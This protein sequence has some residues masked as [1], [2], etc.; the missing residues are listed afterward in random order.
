MAYDGIKSPILRTESGVFLLIGY[1]LVIA[2]NAKAAIRNGYH[3]FTC[4]TGID[5]ITII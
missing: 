2:T 1:R 4:A 5:D 3:M